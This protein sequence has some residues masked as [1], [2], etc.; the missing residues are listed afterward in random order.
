MTVSNSRSPSDFTG[1]FYWASLVLSLLAVIG[2]LALSVVLG[3]KACPLCL[4]QRTFAMSILAVLAVG[5]F[6]EKGPSNFLLL[7]CLPLTVAATV[8]AIFHV[9]LEITGKLEC[10]AGVF[11]IGTAPQQSLMVLTILTGLIFMG[12]LRQR[13][14]LMFVLVSAILGLL[15]AWSAIR[16]APPMPPP[17][18][19][20]YETPL[21][22]CRPPFQVKG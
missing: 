16:S 3:L 19:Q 12:V 8:I 11:G 10:P 1:P 14:S 9:A 13:F 20:P 15:L 22:V 6:L 17:P 5:M 4:Y 18:S 21:D 7:P 2:S